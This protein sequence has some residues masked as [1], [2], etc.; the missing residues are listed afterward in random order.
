MNPSKTL[1]GREIAEQKNL[2]R[3]QAYDARNAQ[4]NK[5]DVSRLAIE[6][7]LQLPEYQAAKTALWY[8]DCRSEL[9]TRHHLPAALAS[10]K[11]IAVPF[12]TTDAK[13]HNHL[14]LWLLE[15]MSELVVGKWK[16]L[17]PPQDRWYDPGKVVKPEELDIVMVPGVGFDRHGGRLGNG[18][19]YYDRLL[20]R[21]R[22]D[23]SLVAVCYECQLF[24]RLVIGPYD[25]PM[26]K[27][28]T[29]SAVYVP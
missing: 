29:E 27:I 20:N 22:P 9:R 15:D 10:G 7:F 5:D 19:G 14:G 21:L 23:C 24:E 16:I 13:G 17:E 25:V 12:C 3:R 18:Q 26:H 6:R 2:L 11:R 28:V 1:S 4:E 8:I